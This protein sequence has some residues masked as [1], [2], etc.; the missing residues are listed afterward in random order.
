ML[1]RRGDAKRVEHP[2]C[3]S[4]LLPVR[5]EALDDAV[6]LDLQ[7]RDDRAH[8]ADAVVLFDDR[9]MLID[10]EADRLEERGEVREVVHG[11]GG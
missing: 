3:S 8:P 7:P 10:D 9:L 4:L 11:R 2:S 5:D 1:C 6:G